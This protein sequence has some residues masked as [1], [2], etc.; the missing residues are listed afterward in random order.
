MG[1]NIL[2]TLDDS[3]KSVFNKDWWYGR[4]MDWSMKKESFKIQMFR[5]VDVLPN[6]KSNKEI[7]K[8][9]KEYFTNPETGQS[10]LPSVFNF[11]MGVG[12]LAPGLMAGAIKKNIQQMAKMF[13]TGETP[14]DALPLLKKARKNNLT[15]TADLLGEATLSEKEALEYFDRYTDLMNWLSK[16]SVS[17]ADRPQI[18]TDALGKIPKINISVKLTSLYS[19]TNEKSWEDT[20]HILKNKLRPLFQ[21]AIEQFCFLNIDMESYH[22]KDMTLQVFKEL[23]TEP[24]FREYRHFGIVIQAYLRDAI[25]DLEELVSF[26]KERGTPVTVRLVKGAYWDFES[27]HAQQNH[28]PIPVYTNKQESDANYEVCA[29]LL[30]K[31]YPHIQL[32]MGSH[33]V[34]SIS[35]GICLAE[36]HNVPKNGYEIQMLFGMADHIKYSLIKSG[37]RLREYATVGE[38]IPGMAYLVRR[39]LENTS[40]ESFLKSKFADNIDTKVL[41]KDPKKDLLITHELSYVKDEVFKNE[42]PIDFTEA[43]PRKH[44]Y[45]ALE[46]VRKN[47]LGKEHLIQIDGKKMSSH[48]TLDRHNPSDPEELIGKIHLATAVEAELAVH[49]AKQ[50]FPAWKATPIVERAEAIDRLANIILQN[51]YNLMALEVFETGKPWAEADGDIIESVDFC[52]YYA[53]EM[54]KM[55]VFQRTGNAPGEV[56]QY[57][58]AARGITLVIAP[59]N[60]PLAILTGMV[61][62]ALVTGNTVIMKPAEQS[63]VIASKLMEMAMQAGIPQGALSF[64]PGLGEEVGEFLTDHKDIDTIAF[65]GSKPVGLHI[66]K[67]AAHTHSGQKNVKRCI[68]EM[69]GKNA[70][71]ID[72]DADLDEAIQGVIYSAFGF[73]GQKCSACSR[74]IVLSEVYDTFLHRLIEAT[75]SLQILN[76]EDPKTFFGPL[77][78]QEAYDK[79]TNFLAIAKAQNSL[80]FQGDVPDKGYYIPPTIFKDVDPKSDLAQNEL[81]APVLAVIK[82]EDID[83]AIKIANDTPYGLTGGLFSRSPGNIDKVKELFEVGN[84]Y[85]NRGNTGAMVERHP[86]G[87]FK[88][89]G[90]GSKTGSPDYIKQF[91]DPRCITENTLRRG[92]APDFEG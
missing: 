92:F 41:L 75:K 82:C 88:M 35:A 60:F 25:H 38:L 37:Y 11:G 67:K 69:G 10:E 15:F 47:E 39:L 22:H 51:R 12:A 44:M 87:G 73:Q 53:Q 3:S 56:T 61:S 86:F 5:F 50:A 84:L 63:S 81:F 23:T 40:N 16:D 4:I 89:S 42:S 36:K 83:Q 80:A 18:D 58:H 52:R 24:E 31:N 2:N 13:I 48:Q 17:W 29:E 57:L 14:K 91:M 66:V 1:T 34:R 70:I 54:R 79:I 77:V 71:I 33:N 26:V 46:N 20:V 43:E 6:L 68:I 21:Q 90:L 85:I 32:A 59:W 19:Q 78:D 28:W 64:L 8:H 30:L 62:A 49:T 74:V 72:N 65:T 55:A 9:L 45:A 7:M 76:V 27:I